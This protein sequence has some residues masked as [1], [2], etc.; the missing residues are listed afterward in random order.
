MGKTLSTM[1]PVAL[2]SRNQKKNTRL[3]GIAATK[4]Y[5]LTTNHTKST[6]KSKTRKCYPQM[7]Q[8]DAD[9]K[10]EDLTGI[11]RIDR[12]RN[13]VGSAVPA[14]RLYAFRLWRPT[15]RRW[16]TSGEPPVANWEKQYFV[17]RGNL[18]SSRFPL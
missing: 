17:C 15:P 18:D 10:H 5:T 16:I 12:I 7:T 13:W 9:K 4:K 11:D 2:R 14:D 8:M 1:N 6:K 3:L